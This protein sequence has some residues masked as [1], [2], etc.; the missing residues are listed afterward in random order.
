MLKELFGGRHDLNIVFHRID[1]GSKA[2]ELALKVF[3]G[4]SGA[5]ETLNFDQIYRIGLKLKK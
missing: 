4:K 3:Q 2:H 1:K 5:N